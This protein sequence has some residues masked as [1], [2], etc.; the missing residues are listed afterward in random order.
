MFYLK[1]CT[2]AFWKL[3]LRT[4]WRTTTKPRQLTWVGIVERL[5][6]MKL[7]L[8]E[9]NAVTKEDS[10]WLARHDFAGAVARI[11]R[12]YGNILL[13]EIWQE[14]AQYNATRILALI[15]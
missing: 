9:G 10:V 14:A 15:E 13:P 4:H 6:Q 12:D 11:L 3:Y 8:D 7:R 5:E 2:N 1:I